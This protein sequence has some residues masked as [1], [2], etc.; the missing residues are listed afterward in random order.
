MGHP[1]IGNGV[2]APP[3]AWGDHRTCADVFR[4][5]VAELDAAI[6]QADR[7]YAP[8]YQSPFVT[9]YWQPFVRAWSTARDRPQ[10]TLAS[11]VARYNVL[12]R[13]AERS[14]GL[15]TTAP[16][17]VVGA[18]PGPPAKTPWWKIAL[19]AGAVLGLGY[20]V[21]VRPAIKTGERRLAEAR[22]L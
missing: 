16:S 12:K 11:W 19:G 3:P 10:L 9:T 17:V 14:W 2:S 7:D 22:G 4:E 13:T 6:Q 18:D 8:M 15:T 5:R 1:F 20:L 21:I